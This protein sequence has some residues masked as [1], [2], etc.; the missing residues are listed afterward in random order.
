MTPGWPS[1]DGWMGTE[2]PQPEAGLGL[3]HSVE[4]ATCTVQG[5]QGQAPITRAEGDPGQP[6]ATA[7]QHAE[8][9]PAAIGQAAPIPQEAQA[10]PVRNGQ[11]LFN[12]LLRDP[13]CTA[14]FM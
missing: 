2:G 3:P 1:S 11:Q 4:G 14:H 8:V 7:S 9:Q 12:R 13:R 10:A 5:L 6:S